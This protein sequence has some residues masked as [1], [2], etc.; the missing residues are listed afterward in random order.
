MNRLTKRTS[1]VAT[2]FV[3]ALFCT[4]AV[5][6]A[7]GYSLFGDA[8][9]VS[10]GNNSPTAAEIKYDPAGPGFGGVD[11]TVPAG[12]TLADLDVL[13]TDYKFTV[14]SCRDG[15]PRFQINVLDPTTNTVKNIFVY[16]GPAPSYTGCPAGIYLNTTNLLDPVD[17]VDATQLGGL[18]YMP[19]APAQAAYGSYE[20]VGIQLVADGFS[21]V[22]QT[23][24][25]DNVQINNS[26]T[27]F[28]SADSCKKGGYSQF[29]SAP[30]PFKNQGQCVSYFAKGGE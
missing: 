20:I 6:A 16:I 30:G 24:H 12:L 18:F 2:V 8:S 22:A 19:Y 23:T 26:I 13:S 21:G 14:G 3:F 4:G 27:T 11:F 28:E 25:V 7:S 17:F 29:T 10:P 5:L 15:S 1:V 9:L